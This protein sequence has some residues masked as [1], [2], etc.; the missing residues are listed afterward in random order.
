MVK[1]NVVSTVQVLQELMHGIIPGKV[2]N[3]LGNL[4]LFHSLMLC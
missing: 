4:F 3:S 1:E 2:F